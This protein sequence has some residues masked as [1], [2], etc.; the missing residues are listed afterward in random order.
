MFD[1]PA[2]LDERPDRQQAGW[3]DAVRMGW[4]VIV[5]RDA[6]PV[7]FRLAIVPTTSAAA[8]SAV[9]DSVLAGFAGDDTPGLPHGLVLLAPQGLV[10]DEGLLRWSPPRNVLLE[11]PQDALDD[12]NTT[13][14]L[15]EVQR[16]GIRLALRANAG[17]SQPRDRLALFQYVIDVAGSARP[18]GDVALI[19]TGATSRAQCDAAF[20]QG[21]SAVLGWPAEAAPPGSGLQPQQRAV[22]EL[23]RM[24]QANADLRDLERAFKAEPLL[25][26]LLL[27]LVNSPAFVRSGPVASLSQAIGLLGYKRLVKWLV[28]LLVIASKSSRSLPAI[29][30]AVARGFAMEQLAAAAGLPVNAHD[31]CFVVGV[32]SLLDRVTGQPLTALIGENLLPPAVREALLAGMGPHAGYLALAAQLDGLGM[33]AQ[34]TPMVLDAASINRALLLALSA[35]DALQS[36]V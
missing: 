1:S 10:L 18:P 22:L 28:L 26:Y 12:D 35:N 13:Q 34:A 2:A 29:Y 31:D 7:G 20:K 11:V 9:L 36:V 30:C 15:Y 27:T 14:L 23:I 17:S 3:L 8:Q 16:H 19:A 21:A 33:Q 24:V 25:A 6:R 5:A 32:F 4:S